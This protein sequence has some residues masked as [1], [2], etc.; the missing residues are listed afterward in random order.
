MAI[1][2][3]NLLL[4]VKDR[5]V[6]PASQSQFTDP[7]FLVMADR[8]I[9]SKI[10]P[11]LI[12]TK[13]EFFVTYTTETVV[14]GQSIY[15][16]PYRAV[17]RGLRDIKISDGTSSRNLVQVT[18]EDSHRFSSYSEAYGFYFIGDK[19]RIV[20]DVPATLSTTLTLEYW[21]E[22]VPSSLVQASGAALV[23]AVASTTVTVSAVPSTIVTGTVIDFVQGRSG[24]SIYSIDKT[25]T[26]VTGT[27][28]TF[29]A[30]V[31]PATAPYSL[32]V[33]DYVCVA[34]T[35][36]VVNYVPQVCQSYLESLF[37]Q[38]IL[39]SIGDEVGA[40][41]LNDQI[42]GEKED[43]L[44]VLSPRISGEPVIIINRDSLVRGRLSRNYS[45]IYGN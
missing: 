25:C 7:R 39:F 32:V 3:D 42:K 24:S 1:T 44:K 17:N 5:G 40:K 10:V 12:S 8:V 6:V 43:C 33:G 41:A 38:A 34:G 26:D 14:A 16:V 15:S 22:I 18:L 35:S 20:P 19:I 4:G 21:Y 36:P 11:L 13:A 2:A 31:I 28:L 27:T 9:E 30:S 37:A 29:G 45:R 23:T